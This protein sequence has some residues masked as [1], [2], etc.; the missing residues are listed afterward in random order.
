MAEWTAIAGNSHFTTYIDTDSRQIQGD[1]V[2]IW[3]MLDYSSIQK[4]DG[5]NQMFNS[6]VIQGD[7]NCKKQYKRQ[8]DVILYSENLARGSVVHAVRNINEKYISIIPGSIDAGL[9]KWA[10]Y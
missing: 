9:I 2:T 6:S 8:L 4:R 10:C 5:S 7:F 1:R 3:Y